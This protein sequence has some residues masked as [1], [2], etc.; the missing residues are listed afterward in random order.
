MPRWGFSLFTDAVSTL[1][2]LWILKY[3]AALA[4]PKKGP[5]YLAASGG[6]AQSPLT[7]TCWQDY[8]YCGTSAASITG[9]EAVL[10]GEKEAASDLNFSTHLSTSASGVSRNS[11]GSVRAAAEML[12]FSLGA[13]LNPN[14]TQ[15]SWDTQ[16][17]PC[18]RALKASLSCRW[19]LST[20]PL[21]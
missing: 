8:S 6:R 11:P 20:I 5:S 4:T 12:A 7:Y 13:D 2:S 10:G 18:R 21:L 14:R 9:P 19:N 15:G 3:L 16:S 17:C 1:S